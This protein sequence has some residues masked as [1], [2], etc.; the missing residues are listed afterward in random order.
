MRNWLS[1]AYSFWH[2]ALLFQCQ[3]AY[4][5]QPLAPLAWSLSGTPYPYGRPDMSNL[6]VYH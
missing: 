1:R 6:L 4:L 3:F 5:L 2:R